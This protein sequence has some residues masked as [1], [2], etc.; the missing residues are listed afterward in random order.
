V[1]EQLRKFITEDFVYPSYHSV[2]LLR[3]PPA[4]VASTAP[5]PGNETLSA[6]QTPS[7]MS[8]GSI[9]AATTLT[10]STTAGSS[11][12]AS[13]HMENQHVLHRRPGVGR[14]ERDRGG[15]SGIPSRGSSSSSATYTN[16]SAPI[17]SPR[18]ATA[19]SSSRQSARYP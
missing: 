13:I 17:I 1:V 8:V 18:L 2:E 19:S 14:T 11:T 16:R 7:G 12:G 5:A 4:P 6:T 9:G 3:T 15:S 10:P